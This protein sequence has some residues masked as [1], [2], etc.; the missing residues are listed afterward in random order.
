MLLLLHRLRLFCT[1]FLGYEHFKNGHGKDQ[2]VSMGKQSLP[3]D[4]LQDRGKFFGAN[5]FTKV[6]VNGNS[7]GDDMC[8]S[9]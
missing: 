5:K 2:I 4:K 8:V 9:N 6:L 1:P 3:V 7:H